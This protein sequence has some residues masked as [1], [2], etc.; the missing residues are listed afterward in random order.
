MLSGDTPD[1]ADLSVAVAQA[2][3][4]PDDEPERLRATEMS[5]VAEN[6]FGAPDPDLNGMRAILAKLADAE[7]V[8]DGISLRAHQFVRTVRGMWAC[9][10]RA[11]TGVSDGRVVAVRQPTQNARCTATQAAEIGRLYDIPA[12][13]CEDCGSRV[14]ELL[15]CFECGDASLGG[16]VVDRLD[17]VLGRRRR[18]RLHTR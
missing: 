1:A 8:G 4:Y 17:P 7:K 9:S 5:Q 14:L 18:R 12:S 13:V 11:C 6:L 2:C 16:F 3:F 15:Y 10:N